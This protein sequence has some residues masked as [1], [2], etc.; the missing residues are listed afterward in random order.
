[1]LAGWRAFPVFA[2]ASTFTYKG[3]AVDIKKVGEEL[4]A[5]YVVEGSVRKSGRRVRV[6]VQLIQADTNH[7][8]MAEKYDR[9]LT[10]LFELQDEI[11]HVIAGAIEPELAKFERDRIADQP[12]QSQDAYE[13][14][15]R[16]M[17]HHYRRTKADNSEAQR[18]FRAALA[19]DPHYPQA[20]AALGGCGVQRR[21]PGWAGNAERIT[22]NRSLAQRGWS[23]RRRPA[24]HFAL[25]ACTPS[26]D[27]AVAEQCQRSNSPQRSRHP[28][29]NVPL[30]RRA[31]RGDPTRRERDSAQPQ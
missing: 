17:W 30:C 1:M 20:T 21:L 22:K 2:R 27:R 18:L 7:H 13:L 9:D 10:D 31:R 6:T 11:T 5:R 16:G 15:Q 23:R 12:Q 26:P 8:I 3:K 14:Y 29:P 28:R 24:A 25:A 19:I 4:G